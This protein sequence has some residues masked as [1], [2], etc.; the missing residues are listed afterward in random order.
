MLVARPGDKALV[1]FFEKKTLKLGRVEVENRSLAQEVGLRVVDVDKIRFVFDYFDLDGDGHI[2][3]NEF[4][5]MVR[6]VRTR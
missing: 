6:V 2:T 5:N 1:D 4:Q 3:V